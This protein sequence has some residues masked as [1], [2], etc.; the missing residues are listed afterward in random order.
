[1][2]SSINSVDLDMFIRDLSLPWVAHMALLDHMEVQDHMVL[3]VHLVLL[4]LPWV[5]ITQGHTTRDLPDHSKYSGILKSQQKFFFFLLARIQMTWD[6][7]S[8]CLSLVV[9]LL[10][11]SHRDGGMATHIGNRDSL[12]QVSV[13]CQ[14]C[15]MQCS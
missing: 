4:E 13:C 9:H 1:M 7:D 6:A 15:K 11:T 10:L 12:I 3:L 5:H 8:Y 2:L 14:L